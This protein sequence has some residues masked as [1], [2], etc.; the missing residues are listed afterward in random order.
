MPAQDSNNAN[1]TN[2]RLDI[3]IKLLAAIFVRGLDNGA[4]IVKLDKM[5]LSRD[6]IADALGVTTHN[7]SQALYAASK[8]SA[9][10]K[11]RAKPLDHS[12][13]AEQL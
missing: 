2:T 11:K 3:V 13:E 7:V 6:Q 12:A 10:P 9:S 4:A 8:K 1:D 5:R